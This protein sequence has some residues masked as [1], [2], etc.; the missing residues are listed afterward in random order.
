VRN[1]FA[2][3]RLDARSWRLHI[4][5]PGGQTVD[6][7]YDD[8]LTLPAHTVAATLECAGNSRVFLVPTAAGAQWELGGVSTATWTGVPLS[9]V[10]EHAGIHATTGEVV[11]EGADNGPIRAES[12]PI[13]GSIHFAR[14]LPM[15]KA[16]QPEVLLAYRMNGAPLPAAHGFPLRAVVPGW[17]GVAS[18]KWLTRLIVTDRPFQGYFQTLD[19]SYWE[20]RDG[21]P[22]LRPITELQVK[23]EIARPAMLEVVPAGTLYRVHGAAW[24]GES[25][26]SKVEISPDAGLSWAPARLLG[27][28]LRNAWRLWEYAW[29]TPARA[30]RYTLMARATDAQ[31]HVQPLQRDRD[32]RSYMINHVLPGPAHMTGCCWRNHHLGRHC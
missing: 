4:E 14:S 18:V 1:H 31:G 3:P 15:A 12:P 17:Y 21:L 22:S 10:L 20:R 8:L 7:S 25:V 27:A 13:A 5:G 26:V 16:L 30:G 32:R 28:P 9:A 6:L 11:L 24:T 19:Y 2:Q 23:A 29:P